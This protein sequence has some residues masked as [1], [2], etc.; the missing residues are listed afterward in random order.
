MT[1]SR[2]QVIERVYHAA[3]ERSPATREAFLMEVCK[4]DS[5]LRSEVESLLAHDS[6]KTGKLDQPPWVGLDGLTASEAPVTVM[7]PGTRLGP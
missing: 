2:W 7:N 3:L 6:S 1:P 4:N 5:E